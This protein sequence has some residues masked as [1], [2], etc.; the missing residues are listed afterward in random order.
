MAPI[1]GPQINNLYQF[2]NNLQTNKNEAISVVHVPI[3]IQRNNL[4]IY[5]GWGRPGGNRDLNKSSSPM[6]SKYLNLVLVK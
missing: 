6:A 5:G 1:I 3:Q 4:R 2:Q